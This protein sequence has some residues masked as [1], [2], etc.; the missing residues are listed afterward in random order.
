MFCDCKR[1][2]AQAVILK[3]SPCQIFTKTCVCAYTHAYSH[4][5][6]LSV[7]SRFL[8]IDSMECAQWTDA[9]LWCNITNFT[10]LLGLFTL[11]IAGTFHIFRRFTVWWPLLMN[12]NTQKFLLLPAELQDNPEIIKKKKHYWHLQRC[13]KTVFITCFCEYFWK[14]PVKSKTFFMKY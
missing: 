11:T 4:T 2:L 14:L 6:M 9:L 10:Y 7:H 13:L 1:D 12:M 3:T 8:V 5:Q